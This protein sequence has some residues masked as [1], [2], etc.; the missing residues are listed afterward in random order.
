MN[1]K[2]PLTKARVM[3][4]KKFDLLWK[5]GLMTRTEA[6]QWL[7]S[8]MGLSSKDAHI[9]QFSITDCER[10]ISKVDEFFRR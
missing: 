7:A 6:Y 8:T 2:S 1:F 4:H 3:A 9:K 5:F 10:L